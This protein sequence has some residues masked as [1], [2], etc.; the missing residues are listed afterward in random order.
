MENLLSQIDF[1]ELR[2]WIILILAIIGGTTTIKTYTSSTRQRKLDN[3]Y[4]TLDYLR[5]HITDNQIQTFIKLF[6]ANNPLAVPENEFHFEDGTVQTI[7]HMFSEGGCGNGD[8][9]NMIELFNL[10][11]KKLNKG[12]LNEDLIWYEYGQIMLSCYK[13]TKYLEDN[14]EKLFIKPQFD[15][16]DKEYKES[17]KFW[18]SQMDNLERFYLDLHKYIESYSKNSLNLPIKHYTYVE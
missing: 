14:M 12:L 3:T 6:H 11:S 7:E 15:M 1:T 9:H 13:W 5:R 8:L 17:V 10:I 2:N 4:K 18:K 16:S